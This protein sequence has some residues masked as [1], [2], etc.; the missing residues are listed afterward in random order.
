MAEEKK[1]SKSK[2]IIVL[3][4]IVI[5]LLVAGVGVGAIFIFGG[6]K[7]A[8][9]AQT[10]AP[11]VTQAP[12]T[13]KKND[14]PLVLDYDSSA[15]AIDEASLQN[16]LNKMKE[17][18]ADG[19]LNLNFKNEARSNDGVNFSCFLGNS[20]ANTHDLFFNIYKDA[21]L[22]EQIYLSGLIAPGSAVESFTSEIKLDPGEYSAILFFSSVDDDHTTMLSQVA[23]EL[24]LVVNENNN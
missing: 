5:V 21:S 19:Y 8:N 24:K 23:V 22:E 18:V 6:Q 16:S 13:E 11:A 14:N 17:K 15:V 4:I 3:L 7:P 12:E 10:T 20:D 1:D 2:I 9:E